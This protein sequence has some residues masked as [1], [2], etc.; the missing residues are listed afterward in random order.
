MKA[1][2]AR[3]RRAAYTGALLGL[4]ALVCLTGVAAAAPRT[5]FRLQSVKGQVEVQA[6]GKGRWAAV[7]RGAAAA[8]T[9][10]HVRTGANGSAVIVRDGGQ[11]I[12]LGPRTEV[13]LREPGG[14]SGFRV[15]AGR[16][17][18]AFTGRQRLQVRAPGAIAAAEGTT[19][20]VEVAEDG[21]TVLTVVEGL[22][23]FYNDLG[24]V[25][26]TENQQSTARPGEAPTRPVVVDAASLTAWEASLATLMIEVELPRALPETGLEQALAQRQAAANAAPQDAAARARLAEA[27]LDAGRSDEALAA[28]Q[29]A[30][31][32]APGESLCQ[33][34]LGFAL[35]D[36]GR[37]DEASAALDRAAELAPAQPRWLVGRALVALGR[38]DGA[39]ATAL[40]QQAASL[41][42]DDGGIQAY[43][44]AARLRAG[45]LAGARLAALEAV[46]LAPDEAPGSA[47][48]AYV[49]LAE[50]D[51]G[52]AVAAAARAVAA[53]PRSALAQEAL[54]TAAFFAGDPA[55]AREA[56]STSLELNPLSASAHLALAKLLASEQDL[57]E[58]VSQAQLAVSLNPSSAPARSTLGLLYALARDWQ[59]S[60]K[61]FQAALA[62]DPNLAEARTG[63][64]T[65]LRQR[66]EFREALEQQ[67]A[68]VSLDTDSASAHNNL[69]AAH[70]SLGRMPE[71]IEELQ[72]ARRLQ[73]R[74]GMPAANLALVYLELNQFADALRLGDEAVALGEKSAFV[75]TVLARIYLRQGSRDRALTELRQALALDPDYPQARYQM[76][77]IYVA[78]DR[79]RDALR[80]ILTAATTDPSAM[81]EQRA[82]AR[83]EGTLSGGSHGQVQADITHS[84]E[85]AQGQVSYFAAG[86]IGRTDGWRDANAEQNTHFLELLAGYQQNPKQQ[87]VLYGTA[88]DQDSGLPG[89]ASVASPGDPDD[90]QR[91]RAW[92]L[93]VAGRQRVTRGVTATLR[94]TV[95]RSE[96][97]FANP[98][99]DPE[100]N[101]FRD[102]RSYQT[103]FSPELRVDADVAPKTRV[104]AGYSRVWDDLDREG[105]AMVTDPATGGATGQWFE[106]GDSPET[107]SAWVE[108]RQDVREDLQVTAGAWWGRQSGVAKVCLPKL[109]AVYRP[110]SVSWLSALAVPVFRT[111]GLELAPVEALA[112]P[113]GLDYLDFTEGGAGRHYEL[114]YQRQ[115]PSCSTLTASVVHQ[116][117]RGLLVEQ[118]DGALAGLPTRALM[119]EGR[120]WMGDMA[121]EQRLTD[122]LSGRAWARW[123]T[124]RGDFPSE[125]VTGNTWPYAPAWQG[126]VR[127]DYICPSGLR[128]GLDG[129][130]VGQRYH[131]PQNATTLGGCPLVGAR[132][133]YQRDLHL[134]LFLAA[135]NILDRDY[136]TFAGFP[137]DGLAV[138]GG[139]TWRF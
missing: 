11:R 119:S 34:V 86:T 91:F 75:H 73:P 121:Y 52:E 46:R 37:A 23:N 109:V 36:A 137:A 3:V 94:G 19:F 57:D 104:S 20:Q 129:T 115:G 102:L 39:A 89:V 65:V 87:L 108:G 101:A 58:A 33:G 32:A 9:G 99:A 48:L 18:T 2:T 128:V 98:G 85:L 31:Q 80:E 49:R 43:L 40:L 68:A 84:G 13:V 30:A 61:Q 56:L 120:R 88:L 135:N 100:G 133:Q 107:D 82:Y 21:L 5:V 6:G 69:G 45:D 112:D 136:S 90:W 67:K 62:A 118:Q 72:A 127:L 114:R 38:R 110:D 66:G 29:Q 59:R 53:A 116:R 7:K 126:G 10:D 27:L 106:S 131:D 125:S 25:A 78:Q 14:G 93:T 60:G 47:Y 35:L 113:R 97:H 130:W 70:A 22:V 74:W 134:N 122:E 41:K 124:S 17:L 44:A 117:V 28:A 12:T 81:L 111:D 26:V 1:E 16:A 71:A 103:Q 95:R 4:M 51:T 54:G 63:W 105:W 96:L 24:S 92:D 8:S 123:Q 50:G 76:A 15:M 83:T 42:P 64:G 139:A 138:S 77:R 79:S 55:R 132:V